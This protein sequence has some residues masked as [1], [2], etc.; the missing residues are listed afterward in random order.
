MKKIISYFCIPIL[1]LGVFIADYAN[2]QLETYNQNF[3][4][5]DINSMSALDEDGW[6]VGANVFDGAN[7]LYNY[8]GDENGPFPAPNSESAFSAI[9]TGAGGDSQGL[10][11]LNVFSDYEN[12]DHANG[13]LIDSFVYR[14]GV[15][16]AA[17]LNQ[18]Y[19]FEFDHRRGDDPFGPGGATV[20][21]AYIRILS[22]APDF[23]L[24]FDKSIDTTGVAGD[25]D[26]SENVALE[27]TVADDLEGFFFQYG[28]NTQASNFEPSGVY[29][30]NISF[31]PPADCL[32][33]DLNGSGDVELLDV[34]PFVA[35]ITSGEFSC[36]ADV[37]EDGIVDLLDVNPFILL[38][39]G[40]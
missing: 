5:L 10:Q 36:E 4:G 3:E 1:F 2:A 39:S 35:A 7:L 16:G 33:G 20:T 14:N 29:Y 27:F 9:A 6:L 38:L 28:F 19:R 17:D 11:Y 21:S 12:Q 25:F 15:I 34:A 30:D 31:G 8:F 26:W 23:F 40:G 22:P 37:N 13:F 24:I 18:T 32:P